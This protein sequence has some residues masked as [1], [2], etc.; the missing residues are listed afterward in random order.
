MLPV[1][2][3]LSLVLATAWTAGAET[4]TLAQAVERARTSSPLRSGAAA[5]ADGAK[6]ASTLAGRPINPSIDV[7][8][9]NLTPQGPSLIQRDIF[10]VVSQPIE[11]GGKRGLRRD[12]AT[13]DSDVSTLVLHS[14]ERQIALDTVRA[15]MRALRAR[16]A[17]A[18]LGRQQEG[19]ATLVSTM[20][21]RV[22]EGYAAE[23]DLLRFETESSRLAVERT[24]TR[25]ELTRALQEL[26]TLVGDTLPPDP[27][28]LVTPEPLD[29]PTLSDADLLAAIEHRPDVQL[30][31]VR[32]QRARVAA[33]LEHQRRLPDPAVSA[34]YK[35]TSGIDTAVA[36]V[37]VA[38]PLFDRNAQA[39]ASSRAAVRSVESDLD[40]VRRRAVAEA[41]AA[42]D[43]AQAL[44]R[45]AASVTHD[46]LTPA[47]G[48]RNA[49][50]AMFREGATDVL[51]LVDAERVY[52]DVRREALTLAADAY[53]AAIEARFATAQ[54]QIP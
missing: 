11:L 45:S 29:V 2:I 4:L 20:R 26:S 13:A 22:E 23:S 48:V 54:E 27:E 51:K 42:I 50:Q 3:A 41:R 47:E 16:E 40:A 9:E 36:A 21:R 8:V 49:A 17:L 44:T 46:L 15:Y 1:A 38:V 12:L 25:I 5:L 32:L 24:R 34:G 39:I 18:T 10:A 30:T 14:I 19:V 28:Q 7:R 53:I 43:T 35:R 52:A 31:A 37:T 6:L 33:D